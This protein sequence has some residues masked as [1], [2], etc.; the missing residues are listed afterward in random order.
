MLGAHQILSVIPCSQRDRER[1]LGQMACRS[2]KGQGEITHKLSSDLTCG[3]INRIHCQ[4]NQSRVIRNK[5]KSYNT[6]PSPFRSFR[7]QLSS[8][9]SLPFSPTWCRR[10]ENRASITSV[11]PLS[12]L[13]FLTQGEDSSHSSPAPVGCPS[14]RRQCPM[15]LSNMGSSHRLQFHKLLQHGSHTCVL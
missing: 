5:A 14:H 13:L 7:I 15:N 1:K 6:F 3:K 11:H 12:L 2:R 4:S 9:L 10:M 8:Q